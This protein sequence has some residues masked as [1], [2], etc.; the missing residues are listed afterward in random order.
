MGNLAL[1]GG[2]PR[3]KR[4]AG[5][6]GYDVYAHQL[7][8]DKTILLEEY[9]HYAAITRALE[10]QDAITNKQP[11]SFKG[12]IQNRFKKGH[13]SIDA[14][15]A[16]PV[17][18]SDAV[19]AP[20]EKEAKRSGSGSDG[21]LQPTSRPDMKGIPDAEWR[22]ASRAIRTAAWSTAFYL[23]TTDILGPFSVP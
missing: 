16:E 12:M 15:S 20:D 17:T 1:D 19:L 5:D 11:W 13:S 22:R 4:L 18:T 6:A 7:Y 9:M 8:N 3:E 2:D 23:I 10:D 21:V 14:A